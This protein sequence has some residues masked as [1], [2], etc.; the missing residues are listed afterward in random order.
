MC[1]VPRN[2]ELRL[3]LISEL[4]HDSSSAG[5]RGVIGTLAKA[6]DI[7][8]WKR[9]RQ[10]V[11]DFCEQKFNHIWLRRDSLPFA[12]S[13]HAVAHSWAR[14]L[15]TPTCEQWLCHCVDNCGRPFDSNDPFSVV[16]RD[17]DNRGNFH[18]F[19]QGVSTLHGLLPLI[20]GDRDP[21]LASGF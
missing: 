16:Y 10:D 17:R 3:R 4:R 8:L 20:V 19:L 5:H 7:L 9:I 14:L 12:C 21:K 6:L 13:T 2:F 15:N 11:T 18:L 1:R